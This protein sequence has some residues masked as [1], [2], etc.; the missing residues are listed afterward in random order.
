MADSTS[1]LDTIRRLEREE[2][3]NERVSALIT[4]FI[5]LVLTAGSLVWQAYRQVTPPP[6]EEYEI[7][8]AVDFGDLKDGSRQINN[9]EKA[10]E[11]PAPK[12]QP[13][14]QPIQE[15]EVAETTPTPDPVITTPEP[16]TPVK[17][18]DNPPRK[19]P[20][21]T[22]PKPAETVKP[23]EE[24]KPQETTNDTQAETS[25]SQPQSEPDP[26][27]TYKPSGS[28]QGN[29]SGET[30]NQGT[31]DI[32]KLDPDGL[33]SFGEGIGG[34]DNQRAP[35]SLPKPV[36][37]VQE[38][39]D[40]QFEFI[41]RPDGTVAYVKPKGVINKPGLVRIGKEAIEKWKFTKIP[42]GKPQSNVRASVTIK[43]RLRG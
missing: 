36:Y 32:K 5:T 12:P 13:K 18:P 26:S 17:Q 43:F 4:L 42:P 15:A 37:N 38:E 19:E 3:K 31:P 33:Y 11:D 41:I 22:P 9:L 34:G 27:P 39:G 29:T 35:L 40:V 28:N 6:G 1:V 25:D 10:V 20:E 16:E 14:A 30:G 23:K 2:R 24:P 7:I 21:P 8:G